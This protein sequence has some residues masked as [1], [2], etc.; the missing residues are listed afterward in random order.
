MLGEM[1]R[2]GEMY[3]S[4]IVLD[5]DGILTGICT[6]DTGDGWSNSV[7]WDVP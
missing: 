6:E 4:T 3:A 1:I 5:P 7:G 2:I